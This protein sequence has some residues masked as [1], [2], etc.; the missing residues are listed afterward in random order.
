MA[1]APGESWLKEKGKHFE[2]Y[3]E[4]K[5]ETKRNIFETCYN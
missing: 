2:T 4:K 5:P 3:T 1:F